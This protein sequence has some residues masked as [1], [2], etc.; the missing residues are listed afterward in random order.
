MKNIVEK[1]EG[2]IILEDDGSD[3]NLLKPAIVDML[4]NNERY[5]ENLRQIN[6]EE[7]FSWEEQFE[8]VIENLKELK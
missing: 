7:I 6:K 8:R 3:I 4:K 1:V 2:G 5:K